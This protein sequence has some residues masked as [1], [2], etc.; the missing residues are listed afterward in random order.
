VIPV[1]SVGDPD[2]ALLGS[3]FSPVPLSLTGAV[4]ISFVVGVTLPVEEVAVVKEDEVLVAVLV[5]V[6]TASVVP[7]GSSPVFFGEHPMTITGMTPTSIRSE[8]VFAA[9]FL[10]CS[11]TSMLPYSPR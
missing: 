9:T 5:L 8:H 4:V 6:P 3:V 11:I 10:M 1:I 2:V 7:V